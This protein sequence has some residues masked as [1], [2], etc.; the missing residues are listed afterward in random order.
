MMNLPEK[1]SFIGFNSELTNMAIES[2]KYCGF[3]LGLIVSRGAKNGQYLEDLRD[4]NNWVMNLWISV[5]GIWSGKI[6]GWRTQNI[7][8]VV[9]PPMKKGD[10]GDMRR[11]APLEWSYD[12]QI[13][14]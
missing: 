13:W 10:P 5:W 6:E 1:K 8:N 12:Q 9:F 2:T 4:T 3:R 7:K 14:E 11:A